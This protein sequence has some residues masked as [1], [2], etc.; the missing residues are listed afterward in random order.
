MKHPFNGYKSLQQ[1]NNVALINFAA[2]HNN[3]LIGHKHPLFKWP[4]FN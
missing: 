4:N 3:K 2:S 1:L